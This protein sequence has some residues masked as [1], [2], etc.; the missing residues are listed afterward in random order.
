[1]KHNVQATFIIQH[2]KFRQQL[3]KILPAMEQLN[4]LMDDLG[5]PIKIKTYDRYADWQEAD[6]EPSI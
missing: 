6:G 1:M 5:Q 4:E 3:E 2:S